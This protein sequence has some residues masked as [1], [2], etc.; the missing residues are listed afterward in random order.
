LRLHVRPG[1]AFREFLFAGRATFEAVRARG[2][3]SPAHSFMAS[4]ERFA[5][6]IPGIVLDSALLERGCLLWQPPTM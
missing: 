6:Q 3:R 5:Q 4:V 1:E 2:R